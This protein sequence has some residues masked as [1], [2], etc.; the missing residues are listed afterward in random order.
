MVPEAWELYLWGVERQTVMVLGRV[1]VEKGH[2][3]LNPFYA[4]IEFYTCPRKRKEILLGA[5][6]FALRC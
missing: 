4:L 3:S 1:H 5:S 6:V 2:T